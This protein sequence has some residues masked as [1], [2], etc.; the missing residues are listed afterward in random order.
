MY[1]LGPLVILS[2]VG[3]SRP[4]FPPSLNLDRSEANVLSP[5]LPHYVFQPYRRKRPLNESHT[6]LKCTHIS[7]Y[8]GFVH[9][10]VDI[11]GRDT[12]FYCS[13]GDIE[14]FSCEATAFSHAFLA[15]GIENIY[16]IAGSQVAAIPWVAVLPPNW[17]RY[18]LGQG[19]M[20]REWVDRSQWP[21]E[22]KTREGVIIARSWVW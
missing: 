14:N 21:R 17:V 2:R 19:A 6:L 22:G 4:T 3:I 1:V 18:R 8:T 10:L 5:Y 20:L 12:G 11:I 16:L 13:C 7:F 9:D 15:H